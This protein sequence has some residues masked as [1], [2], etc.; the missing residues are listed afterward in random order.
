MVKIPRRSTG[1]FTKPA[2]RHDD[3]PWSIP[4]AFCWTRMGT[5]AGQTLEAIVQ[6]KE[7]ERQAGNGL[8][9]WG[10]GSALGNG[11][12]LLVRQGE[13]Y[14]VFSRMRSSPKKQDV[15][16]SSILLWLGYETSDRSFR[17]LPEHLFVTSRGET[18]GRQEKRAHYALFCYSEEPLFV[19]EPRGS[20]DVDSLCNLTTERPLGF[21]QV[22]A[23]VRQKSARTNSGKSLYPVDLVARLAPPFF[24]RLALPVTLS[25]RATKELEDI[26]RSSTAREW[27]KWVLSMKQNL[28][29]RL[30]DHKQMDF[31]F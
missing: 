28:L 27:H 20:I 6:R 4:D 15:R 16:P 3:Y 25:Q 13:P 30:S 9:V 8:F 2:R 26:Q 23:V 17:L 12:E 18:P 1:T 7:W 14:V 10:I 24:A 11:I 19:S 29:K 22:T 31:S 5:E 21:S